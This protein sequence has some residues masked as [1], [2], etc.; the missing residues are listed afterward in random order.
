MQTYK[1]SGFT[2]YSFSTIDSTNN[3][4]AIPEIQSKLP[5]KAVIMADHQTKGK[6]Q[7]ENKWESESGKNLLLSV[8]LN[9]DM[10][11]NDQFLLNCVAALAIKDTVSYFLKNPVF[12]KWPNDIFVGNRKIAGIL[13]ENSIFGSRI[14]RSI[15]GIGININQT[16][17][18]TGTFNSFK[19]IDK[20]AHDRTRILEFLLYRFNAYYEQ[21]NNPENSLQKNYDN[22][23]Y[24]KDEWRSF[25][26]PEN[27]IFD[28]KITGTTTEGKLKLGLKNGEIRTYGHKMIFFN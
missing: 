1:I 20:K 10:I 2:I 12:I 11:I 24:T 3:Y 6:G 18:E 19:L 13:I 25:K 27:Q 14:K 5:H 26:T 7:L 8:F 21:I 22:S 16:Q 4:T 9:P 28:A 15:I 17:F 23:L